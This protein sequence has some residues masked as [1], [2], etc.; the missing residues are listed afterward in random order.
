MSLLAMSPLSP[1]F[2]CFENNRRWRDKKRPWVGCYSH[3]A[4]IALSTAV[5]SQKEAST[6]F[7]CKDAASQG[8]R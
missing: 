4:V 1:A 2:A 3:V 6:R 5:T 7:V 8:S